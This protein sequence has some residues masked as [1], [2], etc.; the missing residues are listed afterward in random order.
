VVW[1]VRSPVE[2]SRHAF[3]Y[4]LAYVVEGKRLI[5]YGNERGKGDHRHGSGGERPYK[6]TT[7]DALL[8]DFVADVEKAR[9]Q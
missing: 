8:A 2:P 4:R 5:G 1:V 6:F 7:I 9:S 3:K